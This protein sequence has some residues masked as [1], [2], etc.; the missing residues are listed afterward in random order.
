MIR[1]N[2]IPADEA[3]LPADAPTRAERLPFGI[4]GVDLTEVERQ[5]PEDE[6]PAL[7]VNE[8]LKVIG[9]PHPRLD[10]PLKVTGAARYS[11]DVRLPGMLHARMLRSPHAHARIRAID[12]AAAERHPGVRAVHVIG[13]E[14][15]VAQERGRPPERFPRVRYVGQPVAAVAAQTPAAAEEALR[16]VRVDYEVLPHVVDMEA[17][18]EPDAPLVFQGQTEMAET[19]GG[20]GAQQ[21]VPQ[22]GN[23]RGPAGGAPRGDVAKG[24]AEA[25]VIVEGVFRTQVQTHSPLETHGLVADW[26]PQGLTLYLST[27]GT[28][29]ARN[30]AAEL[31]ELPRSQVRVITEFMGGGFGNKFGIGNYGVAA[32]AL[33]RR[34]GAPVRLML[35]RREQHLCVGNRPA[36]QQQLRVGAKRDG[37][38]TAVQLTSYGTA[39]VGLGAGVGSIA[40]EMYPCPNFSQAQYDVFTH[41]GPGAAFRAPGAPQGVFAM[42]GVMDELAQRLAMDPLALRDR[43]DTHAMRREQRRVGA[44]RF[45]WRERFRPP[46]SDPGPVKRGVGFAQSEWGRYLSLDSS[47]EVRILADGSVE[48][49]S[50][51]Q[52]LGTGI[53]TALAQVVAEELG[54][55]ARDVTVRI[56]DTLHPIGPNSGGSVT[57]GSITPAARN[58]AYRAGQA[59]LAEAARSMDARPADLA[60]RDGRVVHRSD[61]SRSLSFREAAGRMRTDQVT[62]TARRPEQY[63]GEPSLASPRL[64][65]VQFVEVSVDTELGVVRVHEVLAVHDCGR[66]INPLALESQVQGGV[67]QGIS[68]ALFEDRVLDRATGAMVNANLDGYRIAG[69]RDVPRIDVVFLEEYHARSSTDAFGVAEPANVATAAAVANAIHNAIGVR[70]RE[71]PITPARVLRALGRVPGGRA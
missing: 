68:W 65:G 13:T 57:T 67:I 29:G 3:V 28:A 19:D 61:P 33:S 71:L 42:E 5:V 4:P 16:L 69:A 39:G 8:R 24:F 48:V 32:I 17:A 23:V 21:G 2:R 6:P 56:G 49:R 20:G 38:L 44:E 22:R 1:T 14:L 54:L 70:M 55:A 47:A 34:A 60:F 15:G 43:V 41:A 10:G 18:M 9:K 53:R 66:P 36:T 37:T 62:V 58:A 51:V 64:G 46:A 40:A 52:D 50:S 27:Q 31:F 11:A 26:T 59:L 63:R 25:D 7:P 12:T 35:D 30:E 45:R